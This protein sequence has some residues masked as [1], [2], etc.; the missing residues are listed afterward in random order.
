M[1]FLVLYVAPTAVDCSPSGEDPLWLMGSASPTLPQP[2]IHKP[3]AEQS[4]C[5]TLS[6]EWNLNY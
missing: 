4:L 5:D 2:E 6:C 1:R 3:G